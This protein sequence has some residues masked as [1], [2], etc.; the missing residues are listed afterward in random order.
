[1]KSFIKISL[2]AFFILINEN[3]SAQFLEKIKAKVEKAVQ[4]KDKKNGE[5]TSK[6]MFKN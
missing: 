6:S 1:M 5:P 3:L 2:F 4:N